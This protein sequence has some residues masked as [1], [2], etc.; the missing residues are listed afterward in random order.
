MQRSLPILNRVRKLGRRLMIV[1]A[2]VLCTAAAHAEDPT[3]TE[4]AVARRLFKEATDLYNAQH[5]D[6]AAAK[7]RQAIAI[8][9]T[10]GLRFHLAHCEENLGLLVE[11]MLDYDRARELIAAGTQAADVEAMLPEA[12]RKLARR[13][14]TIVIVSPPG[15]TNLQASIDGKQIAGTVLGRPAPVNPGSH[16]VRASAPG[17]ADYDAEV[18]VKEGERR[19]VN[20]RL[21]RSSLPATDVPATDVPASESTPIAPPAPRRISSTGP[22]TRTYVLVAE[23]AVTVTAL[24]AGV[25]FM[26]AGSRADERVARANDRVDR[27]ASESNQS[28]E[29]N[30]A[31]GDVLESCRDLAEAVDDRNRYQLLSTAGF[32]G[33]GVGAIATLTTYWFWPDRPANVALSARANANFIRFDLGARF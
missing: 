16:R 14:P 26:I 15:V 19:V 32:V 20:L 33:A 31:V 22:S 13:V 21:T 10:P 5:W 7:L 3:S 8:K 23:V 17:Y 29:C 30:T 6:Q 18:T 1:L 27:V 12:Q 11:A 4:L 9:D 25:T 24:A 2:V 28:A